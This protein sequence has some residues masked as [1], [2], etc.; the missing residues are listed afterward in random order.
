MEFRRLSLI[1]LHVH[2]HVG[3]CMPLWDTLC[4]ICRHMYTTCLLNVVYIIQVLHSH[5]VHVLVYTCTWKLCEKLQIYCWSGN[6]TVVYTH[7]P[8]KLQFCSVYIH[9]IVYCQVMC[10][11][12]CILY[13]SHAHTHTTLSHTHTHTHTHTQLLGLSVMIVGS[14]AKVWLSK[15]VK[16]HFADSIKIEILHL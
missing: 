8:C 7:T 13:S 14:W 1:E 16:Q 15:H 11:T 12:N 4:N 3:T 2:V 10:Y 9:C 6:N 5:I